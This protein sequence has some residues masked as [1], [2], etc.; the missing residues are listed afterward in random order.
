MDRNTTTGLLLILGMLLT[1]QY[2]NKPTPAQLA[3]K[4]KEDS[5][6][7]IK[8]NPKKPTVTSTLNALGITNTATETI[9]ILENV[10]IKVEISSIGAKIKK[11][12]L[13][14]HKTYQAFASNKNE[15]LVLFDENDHFGIKVGATDLS[16]LAFAGTKTGNTLTYNNGNNSIVYELP[17]E[18]FSLG[19]TVK[20]LNANQP[21]KFTWTEMVAPLEKDLVDNRTKS[22]INFLDNEEE[23]DRISEIPSGNDQET[24]ELPLKWIALKQKYFV[25]GLIPQG[26]ELS[27][28]NFTAEAFPEDS[29][30]LKKLEA[31]VEIPASALSSGQKMTL[32]FGPNKLSELKKLNVGFERNVYL[33]Y[34]IFKPINKYIFVPLF[35]FLET[36]MKNYGL[37]ILILVLIIKLALTPL[38]Y[39]SYVG[40]AKMKLLQPEIAAIKE[41]VG[42]DQMKLQ[43][44][45]MKLYNSV[46]VSPM[47]GC[48]P[49]LATMPILMSVFFLFPNL[50]EIRQ[51]PFLWANDLSTFDSLVK[52]PFKIPFYG[53]HVSLFTL[54]MTLSSLA[55]GYYNNQI[56]PQQTGQPFDMRIMAYVTPVIFMFVMNTFP[57]ALSFYYFISNII[58]IAQQLIIRKFVDNDKLKLA[59]EENRSKIAAGGGPKK[60]KFSEYLQ[61]SLKAAE[62]AQKQQATAKAKGKK[63]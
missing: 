17:A 37:L 54:L 39:K 46:G 62:E 32:Y 47:S 4:A 14:N 30:N 22:T 6:K 40:M 34:E 9:S 58:T 57:A 19:Y 20:T 11:V 5:L 33:G 16:T 8:A 10:D 24:P 27:K 61:N 59:L 13:K 31:K 26:F 35:N 36:L 56:T 18:G 52:L 41:K 29:L 38:T 60:S 50:F 53:S 1:W 2:F 44:E 51:Q 43:Q 42:D 23:F 49:V 55:Y 15:A 28:G 48:I 3:Q 25:S 7:A 45:Q 12:T 21:G 63:K